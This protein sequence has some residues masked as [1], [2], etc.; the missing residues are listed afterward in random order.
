MTAGA[1]ATAPAMR[2]LGGS[3]DIRYAIHPERLGRDAVVYCAG[4]GHQ[5]E[6]EL[7]L[8]RLFGLRVHAFDPTA[9]SAR[10]MR[11]YMPD[12]VV[13]HNIGLGGVDGPVAFTVKKEKRPFYASVEVDLAPD[14]SPGAGLARETLAIRRVTTVM[15]ALGHGRIDLLKMDIEGAEYA[16]LDDLFEHEVFPGQIALEWHPRYVRRGDLEQGVDATNAYISR[17][18]EAGYVRSHVSDRGDEMTFVLTQ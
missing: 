18:H 2:L 14:E 8:V 1:S 15:R 17:L 13:F 5:I 9:E 11:A 16:V 6:F 10:F 7:D 4:L 3:G 12:G